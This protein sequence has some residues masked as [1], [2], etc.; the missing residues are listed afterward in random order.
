M[1]H[2][3]TNDKGI[4]QGR[5]VQYLFTDALEHTSIGVGGFCG[6]CECFQTAPADFITDVVM[7]GHIVELWTLA[8]ADNQSDDTVGQAVRSLRQPINPFFTA[9]TKVGSAT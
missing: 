4:A 3:A 9:A 7:R 8:D 2:L 5:L 1:A 6:L